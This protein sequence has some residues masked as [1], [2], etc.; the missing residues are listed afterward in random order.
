MIEGELV[1]GAPERVRLELLALLSQT[2][3]VDLGTIYGTLVS[4]LGSQV[5]ADVGT[6]LSRLVREGAIVIDTRPLCGAGPIIGFARLASADAVEC[7]S[8]VA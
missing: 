6:V 7:R 2:G 4:L 3:E 8:R 5:V 1:S